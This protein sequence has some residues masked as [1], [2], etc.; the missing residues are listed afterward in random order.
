MKISCNVIKDLLPLYHDDIC[1]EDSRLLV[2]EHLKHCEVCKQ[3]LKQYDTDFNGGLQM[4]T[5]ANID[6]ARPLLAL[7]K[8]WKRDRKSAFLKGVSLISILGSTLCIIAYNAAGVYVAPDGTLVEAFGFIPLA[9]LF[10]FIFMIS[11]SSLGVL[12]LIRKFK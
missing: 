1:S 2:D 11:V 7:S 4:N 3:E 9:F 12:G 5:T 8:A 10:A 6:E